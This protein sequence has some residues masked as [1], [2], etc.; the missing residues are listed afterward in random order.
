MTSKRQA[1]PM[2]LATTLPSPAPSSP[3]HAV[4]GTC[5]Q[6]YAPLLDDGGRLIAPQP[7]HWC[8]RPLR[9]PCAAHSKWDRAAVAGTAFAPA[10]RGNS[11]LW[12][13][14]SSRSF[15]PKDYL[16]TIQSSSG[17]MRSEQARRALHRALH[18][19]L[20]GAQRSRPTPML[21]PPPRFLHLSCLLHLTLLILDPS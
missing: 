20:R 16:S 18:R 21:T 9:C 12:Q 11:S 6:D 5:E 4:A 8:V 1:G 10:V 15:Q 19:A 3:S 7:H 2:M 17:G 14:E 13:S